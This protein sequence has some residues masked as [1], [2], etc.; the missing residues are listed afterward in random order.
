MTMR[1]LLYKFKL[2]IVQIVTLYTA[3]KYVENSI[4]VCVEKQENKP[5]VSQEVK[6]V[7][8]VDELQIIHLFHGTND[9][10]TLTQK[11][12]ESEQ[13]LHEYLKR[14]TEK[15]KV[16]TEELGFKHVQNYHY[17]EEKTPS[18]KIKSVF[19]SGTADNKET[20]PDNTFV[21]SGDMLLAIKEQGT[22][23]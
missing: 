4:R 12:S 9:A 10:L 6:Y 2:N 3:L 17:L 11:V 7:D 19:I 16:E 21:K 5:V 23:L 18:V 13:T 8:V 22:S 20:T 1:K 15:E 14:N